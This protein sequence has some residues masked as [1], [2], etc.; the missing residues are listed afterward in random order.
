MDPRLR[1]IFLSSRTWI[2][3]RVL[4]VNLESVPGYYRVLM[5]DPVSV[6]G[7]RR[8]LMVNLISIPGYSRV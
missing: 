6:S 5:I 8:V 4:I 2:Q 7:Y 1:G 3:Q